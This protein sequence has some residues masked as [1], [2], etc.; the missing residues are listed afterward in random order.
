V[1]LGAGSWLSSRLNATQ[2]SAAAPSDG[3]GGMMGMMGGGMGNRS[4]RYVSPADAE[5]LGNALPAGAT[6]DRTRNQITFTSPAASLTVLGSPD[7]G[8]D[9]TFRVA[10]LT[11]PTIVIPPGTSVT[12]QFI[13][14]DKDTS[15]GW[16]LSS[17]QPPFSTMVMMTAPPA[18]AGSFV[19]PLGKPNHAGMPTATI[20]FTAGASGQYTYLCPVMGHARQG[21]HG[22]FVVASS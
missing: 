19:M 12:A 1:G 3:I 6:V 10:G 15:H 20:S 5:V 18:F 4:V 22:A 21:M 11:N 17:S 13:N 7:G 14:A 16:L 9:M 2:I 8:P